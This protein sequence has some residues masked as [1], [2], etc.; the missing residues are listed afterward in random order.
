MAM[1]N[2]QFTS[3]ETD[4]K[5]LPP[6]ALLASFAIAGAFAGLFLPS[7]YDVISGTPAI[8]AAMSA[9]LAL[10]VWSVFRIIKP[11]YYD[12]NWK[13]AEVV[14]VPLYSLILTLAA[15]I[16]VSW[17]IQRWEVQYIASSIL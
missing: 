12:R 16:S 5:I 11:V 13:I 3:R 1:K 15:A 2:I 17:L 6:F 4:Y 10:F 8:L 14:T 7:G 9:G